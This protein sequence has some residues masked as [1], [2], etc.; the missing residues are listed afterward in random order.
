[1]PVFRW[2]CG[3]PGRSMMTCLRLPS[4]CGRSFDDAAL[5]GLKDA[6]LISSSTYKRRRGGHATCGS[7]LAFF[8][9]IYWIIEV[10]LLAYQSVVTLSPFISKSPVKSLS[11]SKAIQHLYLENL[12]SATT[13]HAYAAILAAGIT[14]VRAAPQATPAS[15]ITDAAAVPTDVEGI[16]S[17][18]V[19]QAD[20]LVSTALPPLITSW[21][22]MALS[23]AESLLSSVAPSAFVSDMQSLISS[24]LAP[25]NPLGSQLRAYQSGA[26]VYISQYGRALGFA[27]SDLDQIPASATSLAD[28]YI[29]SAVAAIQS[30]VP[31]NEALTDLPALIAQGLPLYAEALPE[32]LMQEISSAASAYSPHLESMLAT[33]GIPEAS[34]AASVA[35]YAAVVSSYLADPNALYS[36]TAEGNALQHLASWTEG[37][38]QVTVPAMTSAASYEGTPL[39][40][41]PTNGTTFVG[42]GGVVPSGTA[43]V[44]PFEGGAASD[45]SFGAGLAGVLAVVGGVA[46]L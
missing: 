16:V 15:P 41:V 1:M 38:A 25:G 19:D 14:A 24:A 36:L 42:T 32:L 28:A 30:V 6:Y 26:E 10:F 39:V 8:Q 18:V 17:S 4:I 46:M 45:K 31:G 37:P 12:L 43:G 3:T 21:A 27:A 40:A 7:S 23:D 34:Y 20:S 44:Q 29:S 2:L 33:Q 11:I 5:L 13:M 22:P 9:Y 35:S